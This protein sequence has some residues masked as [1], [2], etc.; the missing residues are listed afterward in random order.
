MK[1]RLK[2]D[3]K[4]IIDKVDDRLFGS[5]VEHLGR[6]VYGGIFEP[7]NDN[8]D[9]NGFRQDV[10]DLTRE[11][12]VSV[13]RY[14]GGNFV[15]GY[16]WED[17]VGEDRP[18]RLELAWNSI[19]TNEFGTDEF[20]LWAKK[21]GVSPMMAVNLGT[22]GA[23]D[24]ANL[25][26]YCNFPGGTNFSDMRRNNGFETPHNIK[27]WCL[28]NEM[29]GPWQI[30]AKSA[31]D[32][33]KLAAQTAKLM[34]WVDPEIE[35]IACGSSFEEM[36]TFGEWEKTVLSHTYEH[37]DYLSLHTYFNNKN[38][39]IGEF[40]AKS[41][42][43]D[44]FIKTV[45]NICDEVGREKNSDKKINLSFDEYNVWYHSLEADENVQK[46]QT[47]PPLL[48]DI[49]NV[50]DALVVGLMLITLI[51]NCDRVKIA[52][53]AQL[54]NAIAPIMTKTGGSAWRQT[55][56]YPFL[57]AS[58]FGRGIAI[59]C[60]PECGVYDTADIKNI[61][62]VSCAAVMT[63]DGLTVFAVN[64]SEHELQMELGGYEILER[65]SYFGELKQ[66]NSENFQ[67]LPETGTD[68]VL[69]KYSW[70]VFRCKKSISG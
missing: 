19:E 44:R 35:L 18:R 25:V 31:E 34:K 46:W 53:L 24:A 63:D 9:E 64:R 39:D 68:N 54:V 60:E 62:V 52:C 1:I 61:P 48:E 37:I 5:F 21:A 10:L 12:G 51:N 27:L 70:N 33:G 49:Y 32:Y 43:M 13:V 4:N 16:N 23:A 20:C 17:G 57:H 47:A 67:V 8:A 55:I 14:P 2:L 41:E 40:L 45:I 22:R 65:I 36:E 29:D 15:S 3:E 50:E 6:A 11:L 30:C 42:K 66:T 58:K 28:G 7:Q 69:K 26:E 59:K 56:F 38:N